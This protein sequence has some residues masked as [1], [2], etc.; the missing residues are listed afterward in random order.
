[1]NRTVLAGVFAA[2][3]TLAAVPASAFTFFSVGAT[4]GASPG[5]PGTAPFEVPVATFDAPLHAGVT[6]STTG[7]VATTSGTTSMGAAPAGDTSMYQVVGGGG[8][9]T[10]DFTGLEATMAVN[11]VSVYIGSVDTYN[12]IDILDKNLNVIGTIT[13]SELP[14]SSGDQGASVTNRRL[15]ISFAPTDN[16]GGLT[17]RSDATAFEFDTIAASRV[18]YPNVP[19]GS[20]PL[21]LP[22]PE[23][24]AWTLMI[25]GFALTGFAARRRRVPVVAA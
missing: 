19:N 17:F 23:P 25:A 1:M 7:T 15:Y 11:S 13:G 18:S 14:G 9:S 21:V 2:A 3:A 22:V 10:F 4:T 5:D 24:A 8:T 16:F 20:T 6:N 12:F